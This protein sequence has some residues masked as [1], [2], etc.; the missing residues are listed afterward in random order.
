MA[1]AIQNNCGATAG[2]LGG[3]RSGEG[4]EMTVGI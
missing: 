2:P 3:G 1:V 4:A